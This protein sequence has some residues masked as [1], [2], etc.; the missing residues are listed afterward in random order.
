MDE[1]LMVKYFHLYPSSIK[2]NVFLPSRAPLYDGE[3]KV[4]YC[5][6][7]NEAFSKTKA[8][9]NGP[10]LWKIFGVIK[11]C[12]NSCTLRARLVVESVFCILTQRVGV[13]L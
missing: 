3:T 4:R 13:I 5:F 6:V 9:F 10:L 11:K 12:V 7:A 1:I 8:L 2:F